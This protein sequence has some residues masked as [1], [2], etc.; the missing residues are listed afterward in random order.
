MLLIGTPVDNLKLEI[1]SN[2]IPR[3]YCANHKLN[4]VVSHSIKQ[5][6]VLDNYIT[7][8]NSFISKIR[9][10]VQLSRDFQELKCRLRYSKYKIKINNN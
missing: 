10:S 7:K 4:L 1:G 9:K 5:H 6:K 8:L 3:I 2:Q